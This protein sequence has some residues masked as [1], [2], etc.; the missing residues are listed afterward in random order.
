M[1]YLDYQATT[2]VDERVL[3]KMLPFFSQNFANPSSSHKFGESV[4]EEV[5]R[6]RKKIADA[7]G[8]EPHEIIFTSGATESNHLAFYSALELLK[9]LGKTHMIVSA[10]EH[11]SVLELAKKF[12]KKGFSLSI[13]PV[14][15]KGFVEID[16]F[17]RE[18][19]ESTGLVSI[20]T[21]NNEIGTIQPVVEIGEFCAENDLIF[22]TDAAQAIGRVPFDVSEVKCL[23][24]SLAS[25]K[26]YGPKGVGALYIRG[27]ASKMGLDPFFAGGNQ[28]GGMRSGTLNV[29]AIVGF[30]EAVSIALDETKADNQKA[31]K[32]LDR[33]WEIL[34][35][36]LDRLQINGPSGRRLPNNLNVCF[37]NVDSDAL[38]TSLPDVA[39]SN[40][41]AC[42]ARA[43]TPSHVLKAIGLTDDE[44]FSSIRI[45]VGRMTKDEEIEEAAKLIVGQVNRIRNL[46]KR[47]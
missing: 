37:E 33:F 2:P 16:R 11:K 31:Q 21:A 44:A 15:K 24:V 38:I 18:V 26:V 10:I 32:Q 27:N 5:S 4:Q 12:A 13:L 28:E 29:P 22:H 42:T 9:R 20:M 23:F 46:S 1:I 14:N 17:K 7:I 3:A 36:R 8:A 30:G 35:G 19:C 25:H 39:I 45:G 43:I 41:S 40:G 34:S 6:A 47:L